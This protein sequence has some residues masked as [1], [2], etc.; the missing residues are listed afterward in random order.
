MERWGKYHGTLKPGLRFVIP[1]VDNP[2]RIDWRYLTVPPGS[3]RS[4]R[5]V[6]RATDR[7]DMREHVI[8][9]GRQHVITKDTVSIH[10]DALVYYQIT[11]AEAAVFNIQNLPDAIE[12]LTQTTL[13]NIIAQMTLDDTFSSRDIIN[14]TLKD[15]TAGD[16]E[17]WGVTIHRVEIFNINPPH[18]IKLAMENQIQEE[19]ERRSTVLRA[20]GKRE[21]AIIRSRGR[22]A[23]IVLS[24]EGYKTSKL[25]TAKGE[26]EAKTTLAKAEAEGLKA[27][28]SSI[29][30]SKIR[31][32]EYLVALQYLSAL[33]SLTSSRR[34]KAKVHLLP[35]STL[36]QMK[37]LVR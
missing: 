12:L 1:F 2:R 30:D 34:A 9:F 14:N 29:S 8:D 20:D 24:A 25:L 36:S 22:A 4:L 15:K 37:S 16:A 19:R 28:R 27:L 5:I 18:D 3:G 33:T 32:T 10:I 26:A 23:E 31:A 35:A 21:S 17:R 13:R 7:I 11:D 6:S